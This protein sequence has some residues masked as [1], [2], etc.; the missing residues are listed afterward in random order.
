MLTKQLTRSTHYLVVLTPQTKDGINLKYDDNRNVVYTET[1]LP[2]SALRYL[3]EENAGFEKSGQEQL[4]HKINKVAF[5]N[6]DEENVVK[7]PSVLDMQK[8]MEILLQRLSVLEKEKEA[9]AIDKLGVNNIVSEN[10]NQ[11]EKEKEKTEVLTDT[12]N[13]SKKKNNSLT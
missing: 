13:T 10:E 2:A 7:R 6:Q 3:E 12:S 9:N 5:E 1:H 11:N 8:Q 4:M